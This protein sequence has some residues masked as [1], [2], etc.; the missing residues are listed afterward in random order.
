MNN[1]AD[2]VDHSVQSAH[3]FLFFLFDFFNLF[4]EFLHL[5]FYVFI[6]LASLNNSSVKI[7][8]IHDRI[9][10]IIIYLSFNGVFFLNFIEVF[11]LLVKLEALCK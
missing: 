11:L 1:V 10:V 8:C 6:L 2:L 4:V 5:G 9:L 7:T 3:N